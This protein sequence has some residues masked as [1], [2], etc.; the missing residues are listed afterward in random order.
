MGAIGWIGVLKSFG[1]LWC[2]FEVWAL[3]CSLE[4][5][6]TGLKV[7]FQIPLV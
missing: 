2:S 5:Y 3:W 4:V 1:A 7:F 6:R